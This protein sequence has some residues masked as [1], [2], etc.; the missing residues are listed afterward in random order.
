MSQLLESHQCYDLG[1]DRAEKDEEFIPNPT[2]ADDPPWDNTVSNPPI[3]QN[4]IH[5]Q[6][7][8]WDNRVDAQHFKPNAKFINV[9]E[10]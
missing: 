7:T 8:H 6:S 9:S 4:A 1:Y 10:S 5:F 3:K 2:H